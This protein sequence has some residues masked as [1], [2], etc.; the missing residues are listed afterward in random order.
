MNERYL[1]FTSQ[2]PNPCYSCGARPYRPCVTSNGNPAKVHAWR[3]GD[4]YLASR[5]RKILPFEGTPDYLRAILGDDLRIE[6][7]TPRSLMFTSKTKHKTFY[8]LSLSSDN[9]AISCVIT[10][11]MDSTK[12]YIENIVGRSVL[13]DIPELPGTFKRERNVVR[14]LGDRPEIVPLLIKNYSEIKVNK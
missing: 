12:Y 6:K 8:T 7:A 10:T 14:T 11:D 4:Y 9:R 13:T 2:F 5:G 3:S 1:E